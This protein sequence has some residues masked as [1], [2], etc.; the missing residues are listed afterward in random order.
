MH[1]KIIWDNIFFKDATKK[2]S[3]EATRRWGIIRSSIKKEEWSKTKTSRKNQT[4]FERNS[5]KKIQNTPSNKGFLEEFISDMKSVL[6][7]EDDYWQS[8]I[9]DQRT[10]TKEKSL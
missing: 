3:K 2:R 9:E 4:N 10:T 5:E 6:K 8:E 1:M 7:G